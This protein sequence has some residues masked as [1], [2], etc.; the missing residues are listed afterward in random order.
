[1]CTF[2]CVCSVLCVYGKFCVCLGIHTYRLVARRPA[3]FPSQV[4]GHPDGTVLPL[5]TPWSSFPKLQTASRSQGRQATKVKGQNVL[6]WRERENNYI[7][8]YYCRRP[9]QVIGKQGEC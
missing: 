8:F 6:S 1:M 2:E 9:K 7:I 5:R 4:E 3:T